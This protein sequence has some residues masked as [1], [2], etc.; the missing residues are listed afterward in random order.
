MIWPDMPATDFEEL[1]AGA[2]LFDDEACLLH[3]VRTASGLDSMVVGEA[4]IAGQVKDAYRRAHAAGATGPVLNRLFQNALASAKRV[5][6]ETG[7][8]RGGLSVGGIA[9]EVAS[10]AC[11]GDGRG[12][13]AVVCGAGQMGETIARIL[14]KRTAFEIAIANRTHARAEALA[15]ALGVRALPLPQLA[16]TLSAADAVFVAAG[17]PAHLVAAADVGACLASRAP[18]RPLVLVDV[19]VPRGIDPA[20]RGFP[21]IVLADLEDLGAIA[22]ANEQ[23]RRAHIEDGERLAGA[24]VAEHM[25]RLLFTMG[26]GRAPEPAI[27]IRPAAAP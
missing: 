26:R 25:P 22:H 13:L 18:G 5:R 21:G 9:V 2:Y 14:R 3:L 24:C 12:R 8:G 23:K 17:A 10:A 1:V 19:S 27:P 16:G 15:T 6:T 20:A 4:E 11:G 7:I